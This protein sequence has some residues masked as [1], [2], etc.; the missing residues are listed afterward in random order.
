MARTEREAAIRALRAAVEQR[1]PVSGG[2]GFGEDDFVL[3]ALLAALAE[4]TAGE[5]EGPG[6][7]P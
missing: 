1:T 2:T 5:G 3:D 7:Q 6:L 4:A